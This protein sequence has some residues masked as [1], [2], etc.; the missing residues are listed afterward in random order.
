[1]KNKDR[2]LCRLYLV[3]T[4]VKING[5]HTFEKSSY[6]DPSV[7]V[8]DIMPEVKWISPLHLGNAETLVNHDVRCIT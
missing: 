2:D 1:M 4:Q 8:M 5:S 3:I 7:N 6:F